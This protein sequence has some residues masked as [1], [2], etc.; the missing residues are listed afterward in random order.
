MGPRGA[1]SLAAGNGRACVRAGGTA[2]C[3]CVRV[4]PRL[5]LP[6]RT[7]L[8]PVPRPVRLPRTSR[9]FIVG[10]LEK[11]EGDREETRCT[12]LLHPE[13]SL[14]HTRCP[15]PSFFPFVRHGF[16]VSAAVFA[17]VRVSRR[18]WL[19]P[20]LEQT[21]WVQVLPPPS[22]RYVALGQHLFIRVKKMSV[23]NTTEL[24]TKK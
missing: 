23:L 7:R 20:S 19:S 8:L 22:T 5:C 12:K 9:A 15:C 18:R 14:K 4:G 10:Q 17:R 2:A 3:L 24:C 16:L 11:V 6:W 1:A 21:V 13:V